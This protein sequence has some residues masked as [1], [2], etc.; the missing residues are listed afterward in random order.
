MPIKR[1]GFGNYLFGSGDFGTSGS[2]KDASAT[3]AASST[4]AASGG[5]LLTG[6]ATVSSSS[7][8]TSGGDRIREGSGSLSAT[9]TTTAV[10]ES[11]VIERSDKLPWGS[12]LYGYN[13]YDLNDLQTII[14]VNSGL[15]VAQAIRIRVADGS[16]SS[17]S[18]SSASGEVIKLGAGLM[19]S[20]S[21][22]SANAVYT[23]KGSGI[24]SAQSTVTINYI[25]RRKGSAIS[26]G[27]SGT[28]TI[29]REK[30]EPIPASTSP[31]WTTISEATTTWSEVA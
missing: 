17:S 29:G 10:G 5:R 6:D 11:I 2:V 19:S 7:T 4:F 24:V 16:M 1:G 23:I 21:S 25:R 22:T 3:I 12:G 18:G 28:L 30:W 31:T 27:T 9:A 14:S 13:R 8:V 15:T 26:V 20:S